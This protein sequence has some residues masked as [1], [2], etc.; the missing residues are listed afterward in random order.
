MKLIIAT[1][2]SQLALWQSEHVA[3]I[4]KNT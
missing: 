4:L 2:K 3:Q 1:R